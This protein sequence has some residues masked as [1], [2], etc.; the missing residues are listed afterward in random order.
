MGCRVFKPKGSRGDSEPACVLASSM[1]F[2]GSG[3]GWFMRREAPFCAVHHK[4]L[5][6][7]LT[8]MEAEK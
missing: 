7:R 3:K 5:F 6:F 8:T 4:H 1:R 2:L